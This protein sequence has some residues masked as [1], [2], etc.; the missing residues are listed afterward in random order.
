MKLADRMEDHRVY[1]AMRSCESSN[2]GNERETMILDGGYGE[3]G[4][5]G[6]KE[7]GG[8]KGGKGAWESNQIKSKKQ[9]GRDLYLT[10]NRARSSRRGV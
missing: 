5:K 10:M 2:I 9:A 7:T 6:G 3:G 8:K 4:E 1:V